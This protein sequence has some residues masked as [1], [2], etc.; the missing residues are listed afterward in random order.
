[1]SATPVARLSPPSAI[2]YETPLRRR[3]IAAL[4]RRAMGADVARLRLTD[5][6]PHVGLEQEALEKGV[7]RGGRHLAYVSVMGSVTLL[8]RQARVAP[9]QTF[10]EGVGE[11]NPATRVV[12]YLALMESTRGDVPAQI[13]PERRLQKDDRDTAN[14]IA[15]GIHSWHNLRQHSRDNRRL[16]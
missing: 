7:Q 6:T 14:L 1:M 2:R 10:S 5:E 3:G 15:V 12:A 8:Q 4:T 13:R 11:R 9:D 16:E